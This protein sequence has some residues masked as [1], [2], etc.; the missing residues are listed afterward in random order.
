MA[1]SFR[2]SAPSWFLF[3]PAH[4]K[5]HSEHAPEGFDAITSLN[6]NG[7]RASKII[8]N[9]VFGCG[10]YGTSRAPHCWK[11]REEVILNNFFPVKKAWEKRTQ[12]IEG[13][14][15]PRSEELHGDQENLQEDQVHHLLKTKFGEDLLQRR[16]GLTDYC[17]AL[18]CDRDGAK[19]ILHIQLQLR[20]LYFFVL[21]GCPVLGAPDG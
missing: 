18:V 3:F 7:V 11:S 2:Y 1:T 20:I 19:D 17:I 13:I 9:S 6:S 15:W 14:E 12:G 5:F 10:V 21:H 16:K 8:D 4:A